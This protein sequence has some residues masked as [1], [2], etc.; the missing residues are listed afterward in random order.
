MTT[1]FGAAELGISHNQ[2]PIGVFLEGEGKGC[3]AIA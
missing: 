2:I 3:Q 1:P